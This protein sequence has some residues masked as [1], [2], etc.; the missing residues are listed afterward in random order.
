MTKRVLL[1]CDGVLADF[2]G[3]LL[4]VVHEH[5]GRR[6]AREDVTEF[7]F[8]KCLDLTR[9]E[10]DRVYDTLSNRA[11][12]W[13]SLPVFDGAREGVARLREVADVYIVTS[14]WWTCA[15]WLGQRLDWLYQH[16]EI[17]GANV[18]ATSAKHMIAG[19]ILVDD[20]TETLHAWLDAHFRRG[21]AALQWITPHNR[22]DGWCGGAT[23]SWDELIRFAQQGR[24]R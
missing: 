7:R 10:A 13:R 9:A 4:D 3:P 21:E 22:R 11:D 6:Y 1:D 14:P 23:D 8:A 24:L 15:T 18:V 2:I 5:T 16:F 12:W 20:K 17:T 19:D